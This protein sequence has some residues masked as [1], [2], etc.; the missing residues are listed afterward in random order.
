MAYPDAHWAP[1]AA[2]DLAA[3][4]LVALTTD[5]LLDQAVVVTGPRSMTQREQVEA[6]SRLRV[7]A[8][9]SPVEVKVVSVDE[10]TERVK[11][12][13]K[14]EIVEAQLDF[15]K[16]SDGVPETVESSERFTGRPGTTFDEWLETHKG[17][18]VGVIR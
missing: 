3:V 1:V 12:R 9:K 18:S 15:W 6:V 13:R 10:W 7:A 4:A 11:T 16:R 8:G 2:E 14:P 17:R 5:E